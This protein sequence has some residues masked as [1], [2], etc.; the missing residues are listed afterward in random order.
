MDAKQLHENRDPITGEP[1]AHVVGAGL[2]AAAG[3]IAAGA[4][5]GT[6]AGP[7]G[8]AVGAAVGAVLGGLG[9]KAV[10]ENFDPTIVD[11]HWRDRYDAEPYY[12]DGMS[13]DDYSP[14]YQLG[15]QTRLES[16]ESSF[17]ELEDDI[18]AQYDEVRGESRLEW[19]QARHAARASWETKYF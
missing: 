11:D 9:G 3:G 14:A 8:T 10:A 5:I 1:G 19:E 15:A 12:A 18:A 7:V 4:A 13:Y 2:G 6:V 17:D 16:P